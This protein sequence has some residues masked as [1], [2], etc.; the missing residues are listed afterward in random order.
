MF[1]EKK[2]TIFKKK[3]RETWQKIKDTLKEEE[4]RGVRASHY[5]ADTLCAGG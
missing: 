4:F 5:F 1:F 2:V 3:D